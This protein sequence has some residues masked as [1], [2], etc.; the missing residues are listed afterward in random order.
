MSVC[1]IEHI[2]SSS[3]VVFIIY[4]H[5]DKNNGIDSH[6]QKLNLGDININAFFIQPLTK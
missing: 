2:I 6:F 4:D 1:Q 5:Q 3:L